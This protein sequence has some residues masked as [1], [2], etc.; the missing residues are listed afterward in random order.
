ME[1]SQGGHNFVLRCLCCDVMTGTYIYYKI[2]AII[3]IINTPPRGTYCDMLPVPRHCAHKISARNLYSK[4][5]KY[6]ARI[7][8]VLVGMGSL[9][10]WNWNGELSQL[11]SHLGRAKS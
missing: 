8:L 6:D 3:I 7:I 11:R 10:I 9:R 1:R 2:C 5:A 4:R